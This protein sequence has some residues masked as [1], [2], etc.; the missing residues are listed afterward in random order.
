MLKSNILFIQDLKTFSHLMT[1]ALSDK[2]CFPRDRIIGT[3]QYT[4][5]NPYNFENDSKSG[6]V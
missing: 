5:F 1:T 6:L 4:A 2:L 3:L